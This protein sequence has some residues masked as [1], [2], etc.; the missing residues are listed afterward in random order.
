MYKIVLLKH[1]KRGFK[2]LKQFWKYQL[3]HNFM[4]DSILIDNKLW[5]L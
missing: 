1:S 3:F 4:Y 5:I 2:Y